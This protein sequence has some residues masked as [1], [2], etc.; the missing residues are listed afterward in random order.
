MDRVAVAE[1]GEAAAAGLEML[2][3]ESD[4]AGVFVVP[5]GGLGGDVGLDRQGAELGF[6]QRQ[7][8]LADGV[9]GPQHVAAGVALVDHQPGVRAGRVG[10]APAPT[11]VGDQG[12]VAHVVVERHVEHR[13]R[14]V[15]RPV[16]EQEVDGVAVTPARHGHGLAGHR[17]LGVGAR[18]RQ[19][20]L[21]PMG[22]GLGVADPE[23]ERDRRAEHHDPE[24]VRRGRS[25]RP[26]AHAERVGAHQRAADLELRPRPQD[27]ADPRIRMKTV[28][29]LGCRQRLVPRRRGR[30]P[31]RASG[32]LGVELGIERGVEEH[33]YPAQEALSGGDRQE[34]LDR[35][36]GHHDD[37]DRAQ[38]TVSQ[39]A[40]PGGGRRA[41]NRA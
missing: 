17:A 29:A 34:S 2:C 13:V 18:A 26:A 19:Q 6:G 27:D 24:G 39:E 11:E 23:A 30:S 21:E 20:F 9:L 8:T 1:H 5:A 28:G 7:Q 37:G 33:R 16:V 25:V 10:P 36:R 4:R 35:Q 12:G 22:Q 14:F 38:Q 15:V 3:Q 41:Q 32:A 40:F 31:G